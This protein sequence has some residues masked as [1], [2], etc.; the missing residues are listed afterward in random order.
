MIIVWWQH[1]Y[2]GHNK[3]LG[4]TK[5]GSV[6]CVEKVHKTDCMYNI[7]CILFLQI[8]LIAIYQT[9]FFHSFKTSMNGKLHALSKHIVLGSSLI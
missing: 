5:F 7:T 6:Q 1:N 9:K 8:I 3:F 2:E 4:L